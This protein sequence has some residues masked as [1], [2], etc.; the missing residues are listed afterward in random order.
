MEGK[1]T[2]WREPISVEKKVAIALFK[3]MSGSSIRLVSHIFGIGESTVYD[4]LK[5]FVRTVNTL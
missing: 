1:T 2:N 4:I 3:L 5:R